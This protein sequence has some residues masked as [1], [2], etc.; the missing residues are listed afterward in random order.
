[1]VIFRMVRDSSSGISDV[2]R[3][4]KK[5]GTCLGDPDRATDWPS[6]GEINHFERSDLTRS[7][8]NED[9]TE[10]MNCFAYQGIHQPVL[11]IFSLSLS[12]LSGEINL[13]PL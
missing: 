8:R 6:S 2:A 10:E 13:S 4:N 1:V 9:T 12:R 3:K 7:L 11:H 5:K